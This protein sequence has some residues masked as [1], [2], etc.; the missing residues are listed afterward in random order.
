MK[1]RN[2][3]IS[4]LVASSTIGCVTQFPVYEDHSLYRSLV[5]HAQG[6]LKSLPNQIQQTQQQLQN[7]LAGNQ[8]Q[9]AISRA[10]D[11]LVRL[12]LQQLE[13]NL[14]LM[15]ADRTAQF[16]RMCDKRLEE[17]KSDFDAIQNQQPLRALTGFETSL[18]PSNIL[19]EAEA[20]KLVTKSI[21]PL[22]LSE[23]E[24]EKP[25]EQTQEEQE[26]KQPSIKERVAKLTESKG[27]VE[28]FKHA[29]LFKQQIESIKK[30][31]QELKEQEAQGTAPEGW[32]DYIM[33]KYQNAK[34]WYF[35]TG[36][37]NSQEE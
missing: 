26:E 23:D 29:A 24:F 15:Y 4:L 32:Y 25:A 28:A 31:E 6:M 13:M 19:P 12:Y 1:M 16:K 18:V 8:Q 21:I 7:L 14:T 34:D 3:L 22:E 36:S 17:Q 2:L 9:Q 35:G 37:E 20:P 30:E 27:K 5:T 10:I 11:E 33:K